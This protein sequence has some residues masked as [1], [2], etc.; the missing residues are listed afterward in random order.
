MLYARRPQNLD[1]QS[2]TQE[3]VA[4]I[5]QDITKRALTAFG[6]RLKFSTVCILKHTL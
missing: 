2:A 3:E 6:C 4:V 1:D 5:P